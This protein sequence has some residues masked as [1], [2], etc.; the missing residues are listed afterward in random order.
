MTVKTPGPNDD[1]DLKR[2]ATEA[3]W[4]VSAFDSDWLDLS[5][6]LFSD[7]Q[8]GERIAAR[9]EYQR[10]M[11]DAQGWGLQALRLCERPAG[12]YRDQVRVDPVVRAAGQAVTKNVADDA[13]QAVHD[14]L[15]AYIAHAAEPDP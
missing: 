12:V 4:L 13:P 7:R 14:V 5:V 10:W 1:A 8:G 11:Q 9:G 3:S 15:Q 6:G 2:L